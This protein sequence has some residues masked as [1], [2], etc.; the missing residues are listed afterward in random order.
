MILISSFF[1]QVGYVFGKLNLIIYWL[2][3]IKNTYNF[4]TMIVSVMCIGNI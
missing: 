4:E 2:K 1:H 3:L